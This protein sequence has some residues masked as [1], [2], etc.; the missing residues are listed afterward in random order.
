MKVWVTSDIHFGHG[1]IIKYNPKSRGH[2]VSVD[3]MNAK[4]IETF[5]SMVGPDDLTYILG[6]I[7]FCKPEQT[8][9][10]LSMMNGQKIIVTGNHDTR[11][12]EH[13]DFNDPAVRKVIGVQHCSAEQKF[14]RSVDGKK[15]AIHMFHHPISSWDR[16][17]HG[18]YH[19]H[20][21][22]HSDA[23]DPKPEKRQ[24]DVGMDSN[25]MKPYLLDDLLREMMALPHSY[26]GH[27]DGTR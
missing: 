22:I 8:I 26:E 9:R 20:G 7:G 27:H 12:V 11:L 4:I 3:D 5:N 19:L 16:M 2:F 15:C 10:F 17:H 23:S 24:R 14:T 6:D 13:P 18:S 1:N 21:H 25:H